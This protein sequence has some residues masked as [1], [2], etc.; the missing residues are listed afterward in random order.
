MDNLLPNCCK[1]KVCSYIKHR[2]GNVI[3]SWWYH[4][5][6]KSIHQ[7]GLCGH[8]MYHFTQTWRLCVSKVGSGFAV[9][10]VMVILIL[11]E[12]SECIVY[13]IFNHQFVTN[14]TGSTFVLLLYI[15]KSPFWKHLNMCFE[16][17]QLLS[18]EYKVGHSTVNNENYVFTT[19]Q[20]FAFI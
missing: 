8:F 10:K 13:T 7:P 12:L 6:E 11:L 1:I 17:C 2:P 20:I 9:H 14:I 18:K 3:S 19:A 4:S 15:P 5:T 16:V